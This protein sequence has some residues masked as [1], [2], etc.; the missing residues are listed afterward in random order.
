MFDMEHH[1]VNF[2]ISSLFV[3]KCRNPDITDFST[4]PNEPKYKIINFVL[5][6][7][8]SNICTNGE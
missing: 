7:L 4:Q 8:F 5:Y 6:P 2:F 3:R 1:L